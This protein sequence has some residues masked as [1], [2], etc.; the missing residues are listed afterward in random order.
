M[1]KQITKTSLGI[2]KYSTVLAKTKEFGGIIHSSDSFVT[3]FVGL[4]FFGSTISEL[5]LVNILNS[6]DTLASYPYEE[7]PNAVSYTH[8]RAHET[9]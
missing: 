4:K 1:P 7:T 8:L 5:T 9:V 6:L 2:L 3:K